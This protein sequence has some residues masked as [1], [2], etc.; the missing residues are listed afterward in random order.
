MEVQAELELLLF[1]HGQLQLLQGTTVI[2]L[3]AAEVVDIMDIQVK[4]DMAGEVEHI[5][6][7]LVQLVLQ[8]L[9]AEAAVV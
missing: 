5:I 9:V 2:M 4:Q 6:L 1:Q 7:V 8:T 3:A